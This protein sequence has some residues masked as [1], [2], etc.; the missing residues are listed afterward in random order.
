MRNRLRNSIFS[1]LAVSLFTACNSH[2][3][4]HS[5]QSLPAKGWAKSDTLFFPVCIKDSVPTALHLFAEVRNII[6]YDYRSLYLFID[7]NLQ[8]STQGK[9]DTL[10]INLTDLK[11]KWKGIGWGSLFQSVQPIGTFI[12]LHPGNYMIRVSHGMKDEN[13]TGINDIG[14]R[15]EK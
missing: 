15:I 11:G 4:Y 3:V 2:T 12:T 10:E 1:L 8:D 7:Q 13:I 9:T 6:S 14:I 5:Y